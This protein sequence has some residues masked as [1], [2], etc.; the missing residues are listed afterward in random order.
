MKS[1]RV[2]ARDVRTSLCGVGGLA[3]SGGEREGVGKDRAREGKRGEEALRCPRSEDFW[4]E[5][6]EGKL[7]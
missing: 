5:T 7:C 6:K 2:E 1:W 4:G 3:W